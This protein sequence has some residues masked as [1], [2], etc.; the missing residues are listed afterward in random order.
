MAC[1]TWYMHV[2]HHIANYEYVWITF[3]QC[4]G[5]KWDLW[6]CF[7]GLQLLHIPCMPIIYHCLMTCDLGS[8]NNSTMDMGSARTWGSRQ[9]ACVCVSFFIYLQHMICLCCP[10][11]FCTSAGKKLRYTC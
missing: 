8:I 4:Y 9:Y 11:L 2:S 5:T 1:N 6:L 3:I 7:V 10:S